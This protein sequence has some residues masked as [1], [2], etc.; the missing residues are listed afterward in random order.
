MIRFAALL[1]AATLLTGPAAAA[2]LKPTP[3]V[4]GDQI[5][6]GDL[7]DGLTAEQ[8]MRPV[9]I[10]PAPGRQ[11]ILDAPTL[12][13][14]AAA[15][16]I[17]WAASSGAD[18]LLV[19]RAA[20]EVT[21]QAITDELRNAMLDTGAAAGIELLLD[22]RTLS[23]FLPA[24]NDAS[25]RVEKL[26]YDAQRARLT[27]DLVIPATGPEQIRQTIG[28][29]VV[30]MVELPVLARRMAGGEVIG[31]GDI[32]FISQPRDRVQAGTVTDAAEMIGKS[33]RRAVAPNRAVNGRDVREP[34]VVGRGQAVTI[35]LQ[36]SVM[37]LTASGRAL[38]EGA[39]GELVR[40][41]NTSSNRVIEAIVAGPN[42]V[43]VLPAG[44]IAAPVTP[45]TGMARTAAR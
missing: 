14:L 9:M 42:L 29:R 5:L 12:T 28:A 13:R 38:T 34:V 30:D 39:M 44:Q 15:N 21:T 31:E 11:A 3:T 18:R 20:V 4:H 33:L 36:S 37:T 10:A 35:Q 40:I 25:V 1:L 17:G 19:D 8:A 16:G 7:F 41:V 43:T 45:S 2:T 6:L 26:A 22:N 23:F 32:T 24:G 27:A